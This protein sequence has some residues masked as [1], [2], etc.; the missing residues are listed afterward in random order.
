MAKD[1]LKLQ[2][3][4]ATSDQLNNSS[5]VLY[6]AAPE[7]SGAQQKKASKARAL[8]AARALLGCGLCCED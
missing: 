5:L 7:S 4:K 6:R 3:N 1:L 2:P 8:L